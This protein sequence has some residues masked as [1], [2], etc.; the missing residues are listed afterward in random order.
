MCYLYSS[1]DRLETI[2]LNKVKEIQNDLYSSMVRLET[3]YLLKMNYAEKKFT[4]QYG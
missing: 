2:M 4:F 3:D 1:M